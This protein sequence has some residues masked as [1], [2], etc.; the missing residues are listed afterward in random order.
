M[1]IVKEWIETP[2]IYY[3]QENRKYN[4]HIAQYVSNMNYLYTAIPISS[5]PTTNYLETVLAG[6]GA[7]TGV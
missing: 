3:L 7:C 2:D 4:N 6:C 1:S 5:D